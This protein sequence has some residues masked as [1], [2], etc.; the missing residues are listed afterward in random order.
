MLAWSSASGLPDGLADAAARVPAWQGLALQVA[1]LSG[2]IINRNF[3]VVAGGRA[4]VLRLSGANTELL[5][6]D[7]RT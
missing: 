2:G 4:Y 1:P 6:I 7:R 3:K 5:G